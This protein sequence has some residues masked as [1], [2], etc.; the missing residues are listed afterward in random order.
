M[1]MGEKTN[2]PYE[3]KTTRHDLIGEFMHS[4]D[5]ARARF[6]RIASKFTDRPKF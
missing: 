6:P 5:E 3:G 1:K 4:A 2:M